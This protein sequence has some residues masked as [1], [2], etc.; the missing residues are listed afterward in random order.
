[1]S[2][3]S[4]HGQSGHGRFT[5][6]TADR[7]VRLLNAFH[8]EDRS[9][10]YWETL[11]WRHLYPLICTI[12]DKHDR[13]EAAVSDIDEA[14]V[15]LPPELRAQNIPLEKMGFGKNEDAH[16]AVY[17][18][19]VPLFPELQIKKIP[20]DQYLG[21]IAM[22]RTGKVIQV[23]PAKTLFSNL[24]ERLL[25]LWWKPIGDHYLPI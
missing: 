13:L 9:P 16:L 24:S 5:V 17:A 8:H 6:K 18:M 25:N 1:M 12:V 19:L 10:R 2:R 23:H 7:L 20:A 21:A 15:F 3:I 11:F 22:G 4:G 14:I